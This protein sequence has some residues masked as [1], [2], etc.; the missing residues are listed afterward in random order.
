MGMLN[1]GVHHVQKSRIFQHTKVQTKSP[2]F[3]SKFHMKQAFFQGLAASNFRD[4]RSYA[5]VVAGPST[6]HSVL[7]SDDRKASGLFPRDVLASNKQYTKAVT[8]HKLPMCN[9]D[10]HIKVLDT[11][12][13]K[14]VL[15]TKPSHKRTVG[16]E[17]I[18]TLG[19]V[20]QVHNRFTVLQTDTQTQDTDST[21]NDHWD[22]S[23][24]NSQVL[25]Q[26]HQYV[27]MDVGNSERASTSRY[28]QHSSHYSSHNVIQNSREHLGNKLGCLPLSPIMLYNGKPRH[29][30]VIPGVLQAHRLIKES[31]V[32]NFW[33]LRI[34]VKTQFL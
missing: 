1:Y 34:P 3:E 15:P 5:A 18:H 2:K 25:K 13:V 12:A 14:H 16:Q 27:D 26:V 8:N 9:V 31:G 22:S 6:L 7:G 11:V 29:H 24:Q 23:L 19:Q 4:N 10:R 33:G 30:L 32:P 20:L 28:F 17:H 21:R